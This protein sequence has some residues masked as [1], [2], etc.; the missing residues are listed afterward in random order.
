M[1]TVGGWEVYTSRNADACN[2]QLLE[3]PEWSSGK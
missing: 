2:T 3:E 1:K